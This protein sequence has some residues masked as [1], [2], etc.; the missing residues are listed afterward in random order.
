MDNKIVLLAWVFLTENLVNEA[1][2]LGKEEAHGFLKIPN[3]F[4]LFQKERLG[5]RE[6]PLTILP[7]NDKVRHRGAAP[8]TPTGGKRYVSFYGHRRAG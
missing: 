5:M 2:W 6:S 3:S 7:T 4:S 1:A 8:H